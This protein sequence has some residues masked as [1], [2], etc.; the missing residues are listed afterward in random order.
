[1][2]IYTIEE[3]KRKLT[4]IFQENGVIKAILFG[5]YAKGEASEDSDI[6]IVAHVDD[7]M[8]I[9]DFAEISGFVEEALNKNIDFLYGGD[10]FSEDMVLE[11]E[12]A[13]VVIFEKAR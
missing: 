11:I 5:S 8:D 7:D 6:D 13:G 3:I 2:Q 1:M 4:P 10:T 9:L 12:N